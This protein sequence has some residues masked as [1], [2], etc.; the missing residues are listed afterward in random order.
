MF[1]FGRSCR[2]RDAEGRLNEVSCKSKNRNAPLS[3]IIIQYAT[4]R[5][6]LLKVNLSIIEKYRLRV[7]LALK[8]FFF[9]LS[10]CDKYD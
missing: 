7:M 10:L 1:A 4:A 5:L 3:M 9:E 8:S 2:P 6:L